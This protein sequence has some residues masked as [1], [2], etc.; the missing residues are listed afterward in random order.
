MQK[1]ALISVSDKTGLAEFARGLVKL[2][3]TILSTGGTFDFLQKNKIAARKVEDLTGS[4]E[5]LGG[6]VKTLHPKVFGGILA[7]NEAKHSTEL[8]K[9]AIPKIDLV[10]VNLYPFQKTIEKKGAQEC[11]AIEQIDIGGVSLLRAAAKNFER[12]VVVSHPK[13][14]ADVLDEL[15][16]GI[17]KEYRKKLAALTFEETHRYDAL[18]SNFLGSENP[19]PAFEFQN[20]LRYGEN[21]H[22]E[23]FLYHE[24]GNSKATLANAKVLQGKEL[25]FNN[26]VDS[27]FAIRIPFEFSQP[28]VAIIKHANPCG[29]AVSGKIEDALGKA[30]N[31]DK[32]SPF[33]GIIAL[34]RSVNKACA[35]TI[36]PF[37]MEVVI[38]PKFEKAALKILSQKKNLRLLEIGDFQNDS[39]EIDLKKI[40]GGVLSQRRDT[41]VVTEKDLKVVSKKP[42]TAQQIEDLIFAANVCKHAKSNAIVLA[43]NGVA[44]GI[45]AGQTARV[46]AVEIA[47]AKA[48]T[49]AS[50]S[51]LASD[52]FFPFADGVEAAT[53]AGIRAIIHPG[54]SIRDKEVIAA[55]DAANVAMVF[56]GVRGFKH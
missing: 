41:R 29:V 37:F 23:A 21:P 9:H 31:A 53:Q 30:L 45:G 19:V 3:F 56:S 18:I 6:R 48:G 16:K 46:D 52:A 15:Q 34:N 14:Y 13:K 28:A 35:E 25:S 17:S 40:S 36:K 5:I 24:I 47:V 55:A 22:Q 10:C 12:V 27:D 11:E 2:N 51:V 43:K 8:Q 1:T 7:K 33:G 39:S 38:A 26:L 50:D 32:K 54:G 44:V 42:P 49:R 20:K 4:P